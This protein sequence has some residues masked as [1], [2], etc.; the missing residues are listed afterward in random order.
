M[1]IAVKNNQLQAVYISKK[2][3]IASIGYGESTLKHWRQSNR[4]IEGIHYVKNGAT[5]IRYH[6]EM[7]LDFVR[8]LNDP[9]AHNKA[10]EAFVIGRET[11]LKAIRT[12][13]I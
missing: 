7:L 3:A 6:R 12:G 2:D 9:S 4:L 13:K 8:N 1:K 10:I 5:D 11:R